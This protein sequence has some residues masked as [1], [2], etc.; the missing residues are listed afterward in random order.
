M[1][2]QRQK[3]VV[4]K[5]ENHKITEETCRAPLDL[6]FFIGA[7]RALFEDGKPRRFGVAH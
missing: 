6:E 7:I 2:A 1:P 3:G 5:G 4:E